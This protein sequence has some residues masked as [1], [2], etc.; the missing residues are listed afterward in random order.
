MH[1]KGS[2]RGVLAKFSTNLIS[3]PVLFLLK[4]RIDPC[5]G[6]EIETREMVVGKKKENCEKARGGGDS[7][8][9]LSDVDIQN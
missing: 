8:S 6:K 4:G 1:Y 9:D 3:V 5:G 2:S 7:K